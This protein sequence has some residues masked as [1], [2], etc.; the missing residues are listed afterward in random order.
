MTI[1]NKIK[2]KF[3]MLMHKPPHCLLNFQFSQ[4][5]MFLF[6]KNLSLLYV[7]LHLAFGDTLFLLAKHFSIHI[8]FLFFPS[9]A[10]HCLASIIRTLGFRSFE[11]KVFF[12]SLPNLVLVFIGLI[13]CMGLLLVK[14]GL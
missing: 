4:R 3:F 7:I 13:A 11:E 2:L 14:I 9:S 10:V 6:S 12:L 5:C 8:L 1:E